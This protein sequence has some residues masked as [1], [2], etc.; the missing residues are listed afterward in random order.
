MPPVA[1]SGKG[2]AMNKQAQP[3]DEPPSL[4]DVWCAAFDA[5]VSRGEDNPSTVAD[6]ACSFASAKAFDEDDLSGHDEWGNE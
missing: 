1:I 3:K 6:E 4:D 2:R 5:A